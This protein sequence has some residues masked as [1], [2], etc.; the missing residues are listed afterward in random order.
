MAGQGVSMTETTVIPADWSKK[1]ETYVENMMTA[2]R[3]VQCGE[4]DCSQ[5]VYEAT[6]RDFLTHLEETYGS[7]QSFIDF[8]YADV[9]HTFSELGLSKSEIDEFIDWRHSEITDLE[10][11]QQ[12][13]R[14]YRIAYLECMEDAAHYKALHHAVPI[15]EF[16]L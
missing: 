15:P 6:C 13:S 3:K 8:L 2:D 11:A 4:P 1:I 16:N 7:A 5:S 12:A 14:A 10:L 9:C